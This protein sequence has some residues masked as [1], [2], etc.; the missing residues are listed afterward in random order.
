[1]FHFYLFPCIVFTCEIHLY[2]LVIQ[3]F[4]F[5]YKSVHGTTEGY[6]YSNFMPFSSLNL[7]TESRKDKTGRAIIQQIAT[8]SLLFTAG[9]VV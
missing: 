5:L 4:S 9:G 1:M 2:D 7:Y 6:M 8:N 3:G